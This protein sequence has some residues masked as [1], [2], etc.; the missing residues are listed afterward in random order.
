MGMYTEFHFNVRLVRDIPQ[1]IMTTLN[2]LL[3]EYAIETNLRDLVD[4]EVI[5]HPLFQCSRY[6]Y[7]LMSGSAYFHFN[8]DSKI[9]E[10]ILGN[11]Y[12]SVH[13]QLKNYDCEIQHFIDWI[14]PYVSKQYD[15]WGYYRYEESMEPT[16][17]FGK[18]YL[19]NRITNKEILVSVYSFPNKS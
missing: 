9:T 18:Q 16:L 10:D 13:T 17:I 4:K 11:K 5:N 3:G 7:M 14:S 1:D 19:N 2:Y 6:K 12:L 15:L 8:A